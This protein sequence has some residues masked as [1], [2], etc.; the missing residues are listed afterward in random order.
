MADIE[1][2]TSMRDIN[3]Y[4]VEKGLYTLA[5]GMIEIPPPQGLRDAAC[6]ALNSDNLH[7]YRARLGEPDFLKAVE[8]LLIREGV[9]KASG[10]LDGSIYA[11]QGVTAGIVA[12]ILY[13]KQKLGRAPKIAVLE[14]FYTYHGVQIKAIAGIPPVVLSGI[15]D[16]ETKSFDWAKLDAALADIDGVIVCNPHNPGGLVYTEE[17]VERVYELVVTKHK[18]F[19]VFDECYNEMVFQG[20]HHSPIQKR[21]C[22]NMVVCRGFSKTLGAQSWR[23]GYSVSSKATIAAMV[24]VADPYY[25]CVPVLQ[26]ALGTFLNNSPDAY[27]THVRE[28]NSLIQKNW[29]VLKAAFLKRFPAWSAF[30]PHGTMYGNF[31]HDQ[32]S[33]LEAVKAVLEV[34][35]GTCPG[36][37]FSAEGINA[38]ACTQTVWKACWLSCLFVLFLTKHSHI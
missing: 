8:T 11:T 22:D 3:D 17:D 37:M 16:V 27:D 35:V 31:K 12:S 34:G 21:I 10:E 14:P 1:N 7:S 2:M 13:L 33:D 6:E 5:Q 15:I 9:A 28:L 29:A 24:A 23:I 26:H 4:C 25:V 30:E 36:S 20:K 32:K 38:T 18:K 19:L